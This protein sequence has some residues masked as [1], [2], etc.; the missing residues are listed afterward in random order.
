MEK[1]PSTHPL[2]D[3]SE[4]HGRAFKI[5]ARVHRVGPGRYNAIAAAVPDERCAG[6]SL[7]DIRRDSFTSPFVA[8]LFLALMVESLRDVLVARGDRFTTVV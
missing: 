1:S 7:S 8:E 2:N 3:E 4:L 6:P 5:W